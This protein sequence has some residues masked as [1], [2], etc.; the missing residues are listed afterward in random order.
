MA[1]LLPPRPIRPPDMLV[2][3]ELDEYLDEVREA[4]VETS[5]LVAPDN[6]F[7]TAGRYYL[8]TAYELAA[9][10]NTAAAGLIEHPG[11]WE[12]SD[13]QLVHSAWR[14]AECAL[15]CIA[16]IRLDLAFAAKAAEPAEA[17]PLVAST[18]AK[19][20]SLF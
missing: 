16:N 11:A 7:L 20:G 2:D 4:L 17:A 8:Q 5:R 18:A 13:E 3:A 6:P 10:E 14:H 9:G 19:Q 12:P 1:P 15:G